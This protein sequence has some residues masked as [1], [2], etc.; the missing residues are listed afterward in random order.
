MTKSKAKKIDEERRQ[1]T[2]DASPP[3]IRWD[4]VDAIRKDLDAAGFVPSDFSVGQFDRELDDSIAE[5]LIEVRENGRLYL[6]KKG[7]I[8]YAESL[9]EEAS[10]DNEV[11][12]K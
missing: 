1:K 6:T 7:E 9:R 4:V 10:D 12:G 2:L 11:V 3:E 5:G 8:H